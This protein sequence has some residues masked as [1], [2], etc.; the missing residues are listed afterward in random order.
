L[1]LSVSAR[2]Q[3]TLPAQ[4]SFKKA[5]KYRKHCGTT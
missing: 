5:Q 3:G 4:I 1:F 2:V